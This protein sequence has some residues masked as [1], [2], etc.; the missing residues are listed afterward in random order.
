MAIART[1]HD[2]ADAGNEI[3]DLGFDAG[4][5]ADTEGRV[6]GTRGEIDCARRF[7]SAR[8][9]PLWF[10]APPSLMRS[11]AN[12]TSVA[13]LLVSG[14]RGKGGA[15]SSWGYSGPSYCVRGNGVH[16][17]WLRR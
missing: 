2:C 7:W 14:E 4:V 13:G 8:R 5:G 1:A 6:I 15:P 16:R 3:D 17:G 11:V 10:R 9:Y 12:A